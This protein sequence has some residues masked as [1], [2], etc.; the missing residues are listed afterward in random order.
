MKKLISL[1]SKYEIKKALTK[2]K[3]LAGAYL[4]DSEKGIIRR[5]VS[6]IDLVY[7]VTFS[8]GGEIILIDVLIK[9]RQS[10]ET[11]KTIARIVAQSVPHNCVLYVHDEG[12]GIIAVFLTCPN[13]NTSR[14]N[15]ITKQTS[16]PIFDIKNVPWDIHIACDNISNELIND[17]DNAGDV[18]LKCVQHLED[19]KQQY[20]NK[21]RL[22]FIRQNEDIISQLEYGADHADEIIGNEIYREIEDDCNYE[23][24]QYMDSDEDDFGKTIE[25]EIHTRKNVYCDYE[26]ARLISED[27][28]CRNAYAF[29]KE[30]D[31]FDEFEWLAMYAFLCVEV[32]D[33]LY[34]SSATDDFYKKLGAIFSNRE[35][36]TSDEECVQA[37]IEKLQHEEEGLWLL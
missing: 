7:D 20:T 2:E 22:E 24:A 33:D 19:C 3:F 27:A 30:S 21:Y 1:P 12:F 34:K 15:I 36:Y 9:Q 14:R 35:I 18:M 5:F 4:L 6:N 31:G 17:N 37:V 16:S 29:Y 23:T 26:I 8:D 13:S 11:D 32:L 25:H 10:T 28:L